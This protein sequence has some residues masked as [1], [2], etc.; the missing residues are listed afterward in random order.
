MVGGAGGEAAGECVTAL[1]TVSANKI[2]VVEALQQVGN[3]MGVILA[4]AIEHNTD[5]AGGGS[6]TVIEC[7]A[8]AEIVGVGDEADGW[9][10][11]DG[12][13]RAIGATVVDGDDFG[14]WQDRED[15]YQNRMCVFFF[16]VEWNDDRIVHKGKTYR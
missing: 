7:G 5:I 14:I 1:E 4:I 11:G 13:C 9:H 15:F 10:R 6:E 2:G 8:L 16:V 3:V 12:C